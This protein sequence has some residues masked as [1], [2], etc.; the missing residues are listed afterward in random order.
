MNK[1]ESY[2]NATTVA[3]LTAAGTLFIAMTYA[4]GLAIR[5]A[6][7]EVYG[8]YEALMP[9]SQQQIMF[10][11]FQWGAFDIFMLLASLAAYAVAVFLTLFFVEWLGRMAQKKAARVAQDMPY[12]SEREG[13]VHFLIN[14]RSLQVARPMVG[15][16]CKL[17][18]HHLK[19]Q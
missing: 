14:T 8:L 7:L 5:T 4:N 11:G 19:T 10:M 6:Y 15:R 13:N 17:P 12:R 3:C 2:I 18:R 16:Q 1:K 9:W